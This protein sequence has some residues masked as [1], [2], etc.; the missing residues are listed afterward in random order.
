MSSLFDKLQSELE[1]REEE[2]GITALDLLDLPA[3]LRK[4]MRFMLREVESKRTDLTK[5]ILTWDDEDRLAE[6]DLDKSLDALV[7]QGWLLRLGEEGKWR[8][9]VNLRRKKGSEI[10]ASLFDKLDDRIEKQAR[11]FPDIKP[12][13]IPKPK[14]DDE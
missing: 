13:E 9:K 10:A 5:H 8:Y 2:G 3:Q 12:S 1:D 6:E 14:E 4:I 7:K 11:K